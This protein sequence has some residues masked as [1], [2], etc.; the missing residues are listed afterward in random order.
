MSSPYNNFNDET[1]VNV[2]WKKIGNMFATKHA[3]N[4]VFVFRKI[5]TMNYQDGSS[6]DE[7]L[8]AFQGLINQIVFLEILNR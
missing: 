4:R 5:V 6:M 7:H 8:N 1:Q 2:P 3:L